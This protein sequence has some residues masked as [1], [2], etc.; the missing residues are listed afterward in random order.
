MDITSAPS[1]FT[2]NA[3]SNEK[4]S[5]YDKN[6]FNGGYDICSVSKGVFGNVLVKVI[7]DNVK[8][9]SNF[10]FACPIKKN[11][12]YLKDFYINPDEQ[13]KFFMLAGYHG[14]FQLLAS[15]RGRPENAKKFVD[16][17]MVKYMGRLII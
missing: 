8:K 5:E 7:Y 16:L 9:F 10:P 12:Y 13:L 15:T 6:V 4:S 11:F 14:S 17:F 3:K 2:L 1:H